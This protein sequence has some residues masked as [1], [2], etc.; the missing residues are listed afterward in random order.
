MS[1]LKIDPTA[2][3]NNLKII[4]KNLVN[5]T[6]FGD[7]KSVFKG[8]GLEFEGFRDYTIGDDAISID[9]KASKRANKLL[10]R[11]F[12]EERN[13]D[14]FFLIDV[15]SNML[16]SS[17]KKLKSEYSAELISTI[18]Y[19]VLG[20]GDKVGFALFSKSLVKESVL[21]NK[22]SQFYTLIESLINS[23]NYSNYFN[24]S[25]ALK[26]ISDN[27]RKGTLVFIVSDFIAPFGWEDDL[28]LASQKFDIIGIMIRDQRDLT[29]PDSKGLVVLMDPYTQERLVV[30]PNKLRRTYELEVKNQIDYIKK[31]FIESNSDFL[32][33]VTDKDFLDP[34]FQLFNNRRRK[35]R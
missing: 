24:F 14:V 35:W 17:T 31:Q 30:E 33:L 6:F 26:Y 16:T 25:E 13:L 1:R 20:A 15:S 19:S 18:A 2:R 21:S 7:Y 3:I 4:T 9:W 29:L 22:K 27:L 11:E 5:T 34:L 23:E 10:V 8:R 12:I 32:T 28:K